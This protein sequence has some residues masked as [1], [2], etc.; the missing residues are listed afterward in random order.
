MNNQNTKHT[1]ITQRLHSRCSINST[2]LAIGHPAALHLARTRSR[3][4]VSWLISTAAPQLI[5][6]D[7]TR[8]ICVNPSSRTSSDARR[9]SRWAHITELPPVPS[10]PAAR[11][12]T[13]EWVASLFRL[14]VWHTA[15]T[16]R[17]RTCGAYFLATL[18]AGA[19]ASCAVRLA[20]S[21][22][23]YF[24]M[25]TF[26]VASIASRKLVLGSQSSWAL[27]SRMLGMRRSESS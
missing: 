8:R 26:I 21:L 27:T 12:R 3:A 14:L 25:N 6:T 20:A 17:P 5:S 16:A 18:A 1:T 19:S 23:A 13:A 11:R 22:S 4:P 9:S 7:S 10:V 2:A 24:S 15:P